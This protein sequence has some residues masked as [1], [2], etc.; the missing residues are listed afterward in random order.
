MIF[1][2]KYNKGKEK[3]REAQGNTWNLKMKKERKLSIWC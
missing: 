2:L 3:E 1:S